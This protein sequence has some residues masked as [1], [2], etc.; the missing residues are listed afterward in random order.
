MAGANNATRVRTGRFRPREAIQAVRALVR[1]PEDTAQ[2]FRIIDAL[3]GRTGERLFRR[4]R[5][6]EVGRRVLA[7]RRVLLDALRDRS[8]LRALGEGTLGRAYAEFMDQE[9]L[10]PEGL[11]SAS[12]T[13]RT[14]P[15]EDP[16]RRLFRD[17]LRDMHDLWHVV[18]GY[19]RDLV[20][21]A[22]LLA[23]SFAQTWNPGVGLI[24]A[25]AMIQSRGDAAYARRVIAGGFRR[26]LRAEWFPAADWENM[27]ARPLAEV[28]RTLRVG[29][30][31]EYRPLYTEAASVPA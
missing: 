25:V 3:S 22:A 21:E 27:L 20:G 4:F 19:Q 7:E 28:R 15:L 29:D 24:V 13:V 9:R 14:E 1:D 31:P 6:T 11:V 10:S 18:T 8:R 30:P 23:F 26:G 16:D 12:E 5:N 2:V 17:R